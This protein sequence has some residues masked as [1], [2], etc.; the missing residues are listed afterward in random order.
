MKM[1]DQQETEVIWYLKNGAYPERIVYDGRGFKYVV[2]DQCWN[3]KH[4]NKREH[5]EGLMPILE[6]PT[7]KNNKSRNLK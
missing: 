1:I 7:V 5:V 6:L 3:L 2:G 4:P